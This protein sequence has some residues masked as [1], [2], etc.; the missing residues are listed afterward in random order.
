MSRRNEEQ[1]LR[2]RN[3]M[4]EWRKKTPE[5]NRAIQKKYRTTHPKIV[6]SM[7]KIWQD[8]NPHAH[9]LWNKKWRLTHPEGRAKQ[10]AVHKQRGFVPV[11]PNIFNVPV[12]WHH[13]S[14]NQPHVVALPRE[15]HRAVYGKHHYAY[16]ASVL[17]QLYG[18][19]D[20]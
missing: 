16:N 19:G 2:H 17:R 3:Q 10:N 15:I 20:L 4:R 18:L 14:P 11:A 13:I 12:D 1:L 8:K 5:K 7:Q 6:A 9:Y